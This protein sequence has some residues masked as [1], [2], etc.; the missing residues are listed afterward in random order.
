M[1]TLPDIKKTG[2]QQHM[3]TE[4]KAMIAKIF[5]VFFKRKLFRSKK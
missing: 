3:P 5:L 4:K 2:M 1:S